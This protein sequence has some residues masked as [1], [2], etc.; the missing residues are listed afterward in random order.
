MNDTTIPFLVIRFNISLKI[1][2]LMDTYAP[3]ISHP[4]EGTLGK[5][6]N[7][8]KEPVKVLNFPF[9]DGGREQSLLRTSPCGGVSY[10]RT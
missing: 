1:F 4:L 3:I 8:V 5:G 9:L 6:G 2:C 7:F 10:C